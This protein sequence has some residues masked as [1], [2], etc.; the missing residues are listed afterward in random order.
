MAVATFHTLKFANPLKAAGVPP[1][2]AEAQAV[3]FAEIIQLNFKELV[4]KDDLAAATKAT[5]DDLAAAVKDLRQEI[6]DVRQ[7][8]KDVEQRITARI[9]TLAAQHRGE[10]ALL[11]WMFG[12]T[13]A[14]VVG[15]VSLMLRIM[16]LRGI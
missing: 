2:Q 9:D 6:K 8:V 7:E 3:A 16:Y 15:M 12:A 4:T 13:L 1:Q 14:G 10:M 5:K 11:R